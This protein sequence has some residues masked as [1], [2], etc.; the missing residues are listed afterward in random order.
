MMKGT[1]FEIGKYQIAVWIQVE[2]DSRG[3]VPL[4]RIKPFYI[5]TSSDL[6]TSLAIQVHRT[7]V[8]FNLHIAW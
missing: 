4:V 2:H 5:K 7:C 3:K 1:L 6:F 8:S